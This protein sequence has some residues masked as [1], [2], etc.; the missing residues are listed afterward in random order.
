MRAALLACLLL[1]FPALAAERRLSIDPRQTELVVRTWKAGFVAGLG[2]NHVIRATEA[3]GELTW[4][5]QDPGATRVS[6][7]IPVR[8]LIADEPALR[9]KY[10]E[11][12][13]LSE[14]DRR[15]LTEN[16]LGRE[17]LDAKRFPEIR[18]VSTQLEQGEKGTLVMVGKL[19]LH[20]VTRMV[21]VPVT[22]TEKDGVP[23][24]DA[25]FPLRTSDYGIKPY[26]AALG[27]VGNQDEVL[28][29]IH[30]VGLP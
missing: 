26:R 25:K 28:L 7:T 6:V 10:G 21:R 15:K 20:G 23:I 9:R 18:F 8:A 2:H 3:T 5:P 13:D 12:A 29:V 27:A 22:I 16:M 17:Q 11:P 24:G 19:T 14:S 1:A 30:L 4:D